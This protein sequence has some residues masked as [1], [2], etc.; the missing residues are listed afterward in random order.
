MGKVRGS[1]LHGRQNYLGFSGEVLR[2]WFIFH[3]ITETNRLHLPLSLDCYFCCQAS[4]NFCK[5]ASSPLT[6]NHHLITLTLLPDLNYRLT[7]RSLVPMLMAK[8]I[9]LVTATTVVD[10]PD[11]P[12]PLYRDTWLGK[13]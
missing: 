4:S 8:R 2:T 3:I 13:E 7:V 6:A 10:A 9:A 1:T 11:F 12:S 5:L